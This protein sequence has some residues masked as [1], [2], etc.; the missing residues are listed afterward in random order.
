MLKDNELIVNVSYKEFYTHPDL[1][2]RDIFIKPNLSEL[3]NFENTHLTRSLALF[4]K[5]VDTNKSAVYGI[6]IKSNGSE[7]SSRIPLVRCSKESVSI[8]KITNSID[9]L[10]K[11]AI[12]LNDLF[13]FLKEH[14]ENLY[15]LP[16]K[17]LVLK[18]DES[19][20]SNKDSEYLNF[21]ENI[22]SKNDIKLLSFDFI[23]SHIKQNRPIDLGEIL[24]KSEK[25]VFTTSN[26]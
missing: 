11:S 16:K 2:R 15:P 8:W 6:E 26:I 9:S 25:S 12:V 7:R 18:D 24:E 22:A 14:S 17:V 1:M 19:L 4:L 20:F 10:E 23:K 5:E 3:D 13:N 21:V